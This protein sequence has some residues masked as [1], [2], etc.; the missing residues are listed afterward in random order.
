[1]LKYN[2]IE[3]N[4]YYP[5]SPRI[6]KYKPYLL[7]HSYWSGTPTPD[8]AAILPA[9]LES[10]SFRTGIHPHQQALLNTIIAAIGA[11]GIVQ[12]VLTAQALSW[13]ALT[14]FSALILFRLVLVLTGLGL[15]LLP[16][17]PLIASDIPEDLPTYSILVAAYN[18][19]GMMRQLASAL[20]A[21]SWPED[22]LEVFLL[23]E[24]D[25]P[26]T[27]QAA[28]AAGFSGS[29]RLI[30]VPPGGPKTKPNALNHGLALARGT[31]VTVY[32]VEDLPHPGQLL[33]SYTLFANAAEHTVCVQAPLV[34]V[35][36][37]SNWIAAQWALEYDVQFGLLLP[38]LSLHGMPI[39]LGGT[40]N[41]FR[42]N[43]LLAAGGWDAWNVTEDADLGIRIA[44]A[45]FTTKT[46]TAP[47]FESAPTQFGVW[48][49]QRS[50]WLKGYLQTWLVLMRDPA[51]TVR[52]MGFVRFLVAQLTLGGA[53]LAPLAHAPCAVLVA[54]A[55]W[56]DPLE[57]GRVG[58]GLLFAG[59]GVGLLGDLVA[60]GKWSWARLLAV[61]TRPL[62]WPLHSLAAYRALWEL[63][64]KPFFWAKTPHHPHDVEPQSFYSTGS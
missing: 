37:G 14:M 2:N 62:Y 49:A 36:D 32:D 40:S 60:P 27:L 20:N 13:L 54:L 17:P 52:Q 23:L 5:Q 35:N 56:S 38:S 24:A 11:F 4:I 10:C 22:R 28:Q 9:P 44:R 18:E 58:L 16:S 41:H 55:L 34:A 48:L 50:R 59:L 64:N 25:D 31:Y 47:T 46:L 33:Q 43:A 57:I 63:A 1:M 61:V 53:I 45:G 7:K 19:A 30:I 51:A 15:R 6:E 8:L 3:F 21:L 26:E 29:T 12:P 42:R 39:L